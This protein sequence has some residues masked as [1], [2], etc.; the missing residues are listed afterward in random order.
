MI[1]EYFIE[2]RSLTGNHFLDH[3]GKRVKN[4]GCSSMTESGFS[5]KKAAIKYILTHPFKFLFGLLVKRIYFYGGNGCC[6]IS[7]ETPQGIKYVSWPAYFTNK[8]DI[9]AGKYTEQH[10][11]KDKNELLEYRRKLVQDARN[12]K[13]PYLYAAFLYQFESL[14]NLSYKEYMRLYWDKQI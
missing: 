14:Y 9:E 1:A 5:T 2:V 4:L 3:N 12:N 13:N 11:I 8:E 10:Y 6:G 7:Y